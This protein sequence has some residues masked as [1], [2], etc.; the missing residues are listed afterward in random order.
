MTT[1]TLQ[2]VTSVTAAFAERLLSQVDAMQAELDNL[3]EQAD[4]RRYHLE[5]VEKE[6]RLAARLQRDFLPKRLPDAGRVRF[7]RLYRPAGH[8]SGDLYDLRRLDERHAG[9]YLAD[10]IGHGM[11]AALLAMFM[12][13][14]LRTK[15]IDATSPRGY[16]LLPPA[17]A[18]RRLNATLCEQGLENATFATAAYATIDYETG[19]VELARAGHPLPMLLRADGTSEEIG[20][21]GALLGVLPD[22]VFEPVTVDLSPGDKLVLFTDGVE[23]AFV[24]PGAAPDLDAWRRAVHDR[25]DLPAAEMLADLDRATG[26]RA[27]E[28]DVTVLTVEMH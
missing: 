26:G 2:P 3:R 12:H 28:D 9:L 13:V 5:Q 10:A 6:L 14:A 7:G 21:D 24:E 15:E 11:P 1:P 20:G 4:A 27:A 18:V 19:R 17:E 23:T 8:V 16:R 25:R 22:E